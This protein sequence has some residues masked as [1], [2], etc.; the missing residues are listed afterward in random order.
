M[1]LDG[2]VL[3]GLIVD[4]VEAVVE[5]ATLLAASEDDQDGVLTLCRVGDRVLSLLGLSALFDRATEVAP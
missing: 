4:R 5:G 2:P 3:V 1:L